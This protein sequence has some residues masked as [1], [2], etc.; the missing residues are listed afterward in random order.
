MSA[1]Y[2]FLASCARAE[3]DASHYAFIARQAARVDVWDGV[4]AEAERQGVAP[5]VY[6]HAKALGFEFPEDVRRGLRALYVRHRLANRI[7]MSVL[8]DI[9]R[10]FEAAGIRGLVLKGAALVHLVYSDPALRPMRDVDLLVPRADVVRAQVLLGRLGFDAP[11]PDDGVLPNRH[12]AA[13]T[14]HTG[15]MLISVEVHHNLFRHED[16]PLSFEMDNVTVSPCSFALRGCEIAVNALGYEDMLWHLCQHMRLSAGVFGANRLIWAADIVSFAERFV[17]DVNWSHVQAR[18]PSVLKTLS[19]LHFLT[20]LSAPLLTQAGIRPGDEPEGIGADFAGWPRASLREQRAKGWGG[21]LRDTLFPAE[22]WL[23]L[24]YELGGA[25]PL[26][27]ARWVRHP[28]HIA[29]WVRQLA[30]E[31]LGIRRSL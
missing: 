27:F 26:W 3:C 7:R 21:I 29:G 28:L 25:D 23:R 9:L 17:A 10:A 14:R 19:L 2:R 12:M 6:W 13:A 22:W 15:G 4:L 20:P 24:Y 16:L 31:R 11:L 1:V 18:Y 30:L 5:L 8:C